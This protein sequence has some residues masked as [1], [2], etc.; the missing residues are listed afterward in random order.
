MDEIA[1]DN[2]IQEDIEDQSQQMHYNIY[3]QKVQQLQQ[4]TYNYSQAGGWDN[5]VIQ[6]F[7]KQQA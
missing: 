7:G 1:V 5:Q 4:T 2:Q 3:S 6:A